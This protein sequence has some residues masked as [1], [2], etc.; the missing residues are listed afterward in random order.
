MN[1]LIR[2]DSSS[3]IGTGHIM[4]DLVL[5]SQFENVTF[6][7]RDLSGNINFKI[8]EAGYNLEIVKD[9]TLPEL[10]RVVDICSPDLVIIDNYDINYNFERALKDKYPNIQLM[11]FDDVYQKH[12]CDILINHNV[13]ADKT[14]YK[15]LVPERCELRC[16]SK[17]T[18]IRREFYEYREKPKQK[19]KV[20]HVFL[21]MGGADHS[22]INIPILEVIREIGGIHVNVLTTTTN[23]NLEQLKEFCL[24]KSWITIHINSIEVAKLMH[25]SDFAIVSPSVTLNEVLFMRLPFT[26]IMTADNQLDMYDYLEKKGY[27]LLE[28]MDQRLLKINVLKLMQDIKN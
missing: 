13:S 10:S 16:G 2:A 21:A 25:E 1:V 11:V 5:A 7:T 17:Y 23:R 19:N 18:L 20:P 4:R 8:K 9:N 28:K 22:N 26:G 14:R 27:L 3:S 24:D 15:G 6:V 12:Y